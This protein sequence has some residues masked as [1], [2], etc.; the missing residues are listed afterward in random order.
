MIVGR[1]IKDERQWEQTYRDVLDKGFNF[2]PL[3]APLCGAVPYGSTHL[4]PSWLMKVLE[5]KH[6]IRVVGFQEAA[7]A[8]H[9][10]ALA[11][12]RRPLTT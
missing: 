11:I 10:D 5:Q 6:G 7:W 3:I 4:T 8:G 1:S 12:Q 2:H 9:Q